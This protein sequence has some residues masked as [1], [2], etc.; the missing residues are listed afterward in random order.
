MDKKV[1]GFF[2]VT[3]AKAVLSIIL[4]FLYL[5]MGFVCA[6]TYADFTGYIST[7]GSILEFISFIP[8][9]IAFKLPLLWLFYFILFY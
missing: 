5:A 3:I 4:F 1:K 6:P 9:S 2:R 7:C 8:I